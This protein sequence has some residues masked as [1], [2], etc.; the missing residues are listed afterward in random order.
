MKR[1][2]RSVRLQHG[3]P[4]NHHISELAVI[5]ERIAWMVEPNEDELTGSGTFGGQPTQ[6][7]IADTDIDT[8]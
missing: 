8:M 6:L 5:G 1:F 7:F 3:A 4:S 2:K